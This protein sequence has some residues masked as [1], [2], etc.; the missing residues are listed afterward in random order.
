MNNETNLTADQMR[1]VTELASRIA[2]EQYH[3]E[4]KKTKKEIRDRRLHNTKLL[5]ENYRGFV[6]H[7][8]L[9]VYKATQVKDDLDFHSLLVLMGCESDDKLPSVQSIQE[10]AANTRII[11]EHIDFMLDYYK[12]RCESSFKAEDGRRYRVVYGTYISPT[13]KSAQ[14]IAD[15]E[16]I[17][18]S[19]VYKDLKAGLRQLSALMFGYVDL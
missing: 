15:E 7:S 2:I 8:K 6:N 10:S 3:K 19:T 13:P 14:Q 9:A 12:E 17:D 5:M 18:I 16:L 4:A 11:V 1:E